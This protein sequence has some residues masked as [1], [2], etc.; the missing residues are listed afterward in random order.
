MTREQS[1]MNATRKSVIPFE[2]RSLES[3][4]VFHYNNRVAVSR[5][6]RTIKSVYEESAL[7]SD[8]GFILN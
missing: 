2:T 1:E 8:S 5:N 6:F 7:N 3:S 4:Q